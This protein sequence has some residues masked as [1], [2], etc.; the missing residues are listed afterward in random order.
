MTEV[1]LAHGCDIEDTI[2]FSG[3]ANALFELCYHWPMDQAHPSTAGRTLEY[4][5]GIGYEL[6]K[7]NHRGQT[8]LLWTAS[9]YQP[10]V[11]KCLR[12]FLNKDANLNAVDAAGRGVVHSALAAP[13]ILD[14]WRTLTI[15]IHGVHVTE[16]YG[17]PHLIYHTESTAH[18]V[19][20]S[21][22]ALESSPL[23][24]QDSPSL[25]DSEAYLSQT[26]HYGTIQ[27]IHDSTD[28]IST[29]FD[30]APTG[31]SPVEDPTLEEYVLI[32]DPTGVE[33][34]VKNPIHVLK[35]RL[36]YKLLTLLQSGC[37]PNILDKAGASP[38]DY[39]RRDGLWPQWSWAL[40]KSGHIYDARNDR[41]VRVGRFEN[42]QQ[43]S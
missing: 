25:L 39:A 1:V 2:G 15:T 5:I 32:L 4:L 26:D 31:S 24:E 22:Q 12:I 6:E 17:L 13:H 43:Y 10:Q 41:W 40:E 23:G 20:Y 11:I 16:L 35:T 19:D 36:R 30:S 33:H 37:D 3:Q 38:S 27:E 7:K 34:L 14:S 29:I 18:A 42:P 28:N 9:S 21:D 8:P